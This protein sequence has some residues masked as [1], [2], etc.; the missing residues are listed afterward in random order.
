MR[1]EK[2]SALLNCLKH[3]PVQDILIF[4]SDEK[5][6]SQVQKV[7]SRKNRWQCDDPSD[8]LIFVKIKFLAMVMV[9]GVVSNKGDVM[10]PPHIFKAGLRMNTE[11]YID[12]LTNVVKP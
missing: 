2:A 10:P 9:R 4:F 1:Y 5:N 7:N 12:V 6:F 11:V 8:V 3:P